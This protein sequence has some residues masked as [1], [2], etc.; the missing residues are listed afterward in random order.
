MTS[1]TRG[2]ATYSNDAAHAGGR[3]MPCGRLR[4]GRCGLQV[5]EDLLLQRR[6]I[7][8]KGKFFRVLEQEPSTEPTVSWNNLED[9]EIKNGVRQEV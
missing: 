6:S 9:K 3:A 5:F 7:E 8:E 1:P 2:D 4:G